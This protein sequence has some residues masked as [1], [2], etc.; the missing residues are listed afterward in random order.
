MIRFAYTTALTVLALA[1]ACGGRSSA[2]PYDYDLPGSTD[3]V[4]TNGATTTGMLAGVGGA[5]AGGGGTTTVG[6]TS[7]VPEPTSVSGAGPM[8]A[9]GAATGAAGTGAT[10][11]SGSMTTGN[12][13]AA[14][15]AASG[16]MTTGPQSSAASGGMTSTT[17][18]SAASGGIANCVS[19]TFTKCPTA[20]ACLQKQACIDGASCT[21]QK[22]LSGGAPDFA[23]ALKCFNGDFMAAKDAIMAITCLA[24]QCAAECQGGFGG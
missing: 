23:C 2:D 1:Q 7:G 20:L 9:S 18:S 11:G 14:S 17:A 16:G 21:L 8:A 24:T 10:T 19:C 5:T 6:T 3:A 13:V 15:S 4:T 12:G 22:C